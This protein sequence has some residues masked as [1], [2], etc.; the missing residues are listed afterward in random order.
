MQYLEV[1]IPHEPP[2]RYPIGSEPLLIGRGADCDIRIDRANVG[3]RHACVSRELIVKAIDQGAGGVHHHGR[4]V[5]RQVIEPGDSFELDPAGSIRIWVRN[6]QDGSALPQP[7]AA[8]AEIAELQ[9]CIRRLENEK[10]ELVARIAN[11]EAQ[12]ARRSDETARQIPLLTAQAAQSWLCDLL[13]QV[14]SVPLPP[15]VVQAHLRFV[16]GELVK[17]SGAMEQTTGAPP[18]SGSHRVTEL[19]RLVFESDPPTRGRKAFSEFLQRLRVDAVLA[20]TRTYCKAVAQW[21]CHVHDELSA[22]HGRGPRNLDLFGLRH[23]AV[24]KDLE[25]LIGAL[26]PDIALDEIGRLWQRMKEANNGQ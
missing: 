22:L 6:G 11:L 10:G 18:E 17:F 14:P 5:P 12:L 7:Q 3:E 8:G 9:A 4:V 26:T 15:D 13:G 21:V 19:L 24:W 2:R 20:G 16:L 25:S 23:A 1:D